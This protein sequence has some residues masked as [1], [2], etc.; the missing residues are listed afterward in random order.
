MT[1]DYLI[2]LGG[3]VL[4]GAFFYGL[5][6]RQQKRSAGA[7]RGRAAEYRR[8]FDNAVTQHPADLVQDA[9]QAG[10]AF[11]RPKAAG[12]AHRR[13]RWP[14][15]RA[16]ARACRQCGC[17]DRAACAGGCWWVTA[18]MCSRCVWLLAREL[19]PPQ[20]EE[21]DGEAVWDDDRVRDWERDLAAGQAEQPAGRHHRTE[22][23]AVTPAD[24]GHIDRRAL[25]ELA[26]G[27]ARDDGGPGTGTGRSTVLEREG[28]PTLISTGAVYAELAELA[29]DGDAVPEP[30]PP[31][32]GPVTPPDPAPG[33]PLASEPAP[34]AETCGDVM[35]GDASRSC[36]LRPGHPD[37]PADRHLQLVPDGHGGQVGTAQWPVVHGPG[38][39]LAAAPV[40]H[41]AAGEPAPRWIAVDPAQ[42]GPAARWPLPCPLDDDPGLAETTLTDMVPLV[43]EQDGLS[44]GMSQRAFDLTLH[45]WSARVLAEG[46]DRTSRLLGDIEDGGWRDDFFPDSRPAIAAPKR[47]ALPA[48]RT[49]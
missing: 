2:A 41:A 16:R 13:R 33:L 8:G 10:L 19:D 22:P 28:P 44:M 23:L 36:G 4:L 5:G 17:T 38:T 47:L 34:A 45:A 18:D 14:W 27:P 39:A 7:D 42:C 30:G 32:P 9:W 48:G 21:W 1:R 35:P 46:A 12:P 6:W 24:T 43:C 49:R 37:G 25:A 29:E 40:Q 31:E 11:G 20:R 15:G 26:A 3:A